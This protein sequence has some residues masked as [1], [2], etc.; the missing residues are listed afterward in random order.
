MS[1][2]KR[3]KKGYFP[4]NW[5]AIA[6]SPSEW[7][8][9]IPFDE[10]MDWKLGGYQIPSSISCIIREERLDTGKITEYVYK[11]DGRARNKAKSI[12]NEGISEFIVATS[13]AVHHVYPKEIED[14]DPFT[15]K[16]EDPLA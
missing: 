11:T 16:Y 8:D 1:K 13:E 2:K 7:F 12:M 3:K 9:S 6:G 5:E 4:N 14:Y 15:E 10:F